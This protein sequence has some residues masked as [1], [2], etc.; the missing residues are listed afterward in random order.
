MN[1]KLYSHGSHGGNG[2]DVDRTAHVTDHSEY[3]DLSFRAIGQF[4]IGLGAI[5]AISYL[6]MYGI[7]QLFESQYEKNDVPPPPTASPGWDRPAIDVQ[8]SPH[9]D[10]VEFR[11]QEDSVLRETNPARKKLSVDEA[12]DA[13]LREGLPYRN[14]TAA[15]QTD[16]IDSST[17]EIEEEPEQS[18][19]EESV[20]S[21]N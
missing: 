15:A 20:K 5:V 19:E 2:G 18:S 13:T 1:S 10:L 14:G 6:A 9:L 12:I 16:D 21:E 7:L 11:G 4:F 3:N 8:T 17:I